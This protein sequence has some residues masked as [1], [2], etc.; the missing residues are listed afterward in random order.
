MGLVD[1]DSLGKLYTQAVHILYI[2]KHIKNIYFFHLFI[3]A[4]SLHIKDLRQFISYHLLV[5]II[6]EVKTKRCPRR[7]GKVT[8]GSSPPVGSGLEQQLFLQNIIYEGFTENE[9]SGKFV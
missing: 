5:G 6:L 7:I 1:K 8:M 4:L 2:Y 9:A 3:Y